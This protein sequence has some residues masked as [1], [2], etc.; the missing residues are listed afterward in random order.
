MRT[1]HATR[2]RRS[3]REVSCSQ[4]ARKRKP[5]D[6]SERIVLAPGSAACCGRRSLLSRTW[7]SC[8]RR[9]SKARAL[10]ARAAGE[11][12]SKPFMDVRTLL[13]LS[14]P[15]S[16]QLLCPVVE[17]RM[18][19]GFFGSTAVAISMSVSASVMKLCTKKARG[20]AAS[21]S[22]SMGT[23]RGISIQGRATRCP[24]SCDGQ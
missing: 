14:P 11:E 19:Y 22:S 8:T 16:V 20:E 9:I 21:V 4:R 6:A 23:P 12:R 3:K 10:M 24:T 17:G 18:L 13:V 5:G 7:Y 2:T 1:E 15:P